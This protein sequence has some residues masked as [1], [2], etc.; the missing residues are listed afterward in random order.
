M[1]NETLFELKR[2]LENIKKTQGELK[3]QN[4]TILLAF[5]DGVLSSTTIED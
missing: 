3:K 5:L 4:T 2:M 1:K